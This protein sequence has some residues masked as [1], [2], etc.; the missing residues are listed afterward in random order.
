MEAETPLVLLEFQDSI[1]EP[2]TPLITLR[3]KAELKVT[4]PS[5]Q[6]YPWNDYSMPQPKTEA[7]EIVDA[8]RALRRLVIAFRSH[9]KG[10]LA[11]FKDKIEHARMSKGDIG[12]ALRKRLVDDKVLIV[13]GPM[14]FLDPKAL[15]SV[16]GLS[17]QDAKVK[18]YGPRTRAY[19]QAVIE[20][21]K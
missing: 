3:A 2:A 6:A 15:G 11:R 9:S 5:A 18:S 14:Y 8:L 7:P 13:D 4:W 10:Q 19:V 12:E 1:A 17:F 21:T 16:V 20:T